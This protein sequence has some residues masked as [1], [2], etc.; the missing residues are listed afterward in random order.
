[1][2]PVP[3]SLD[4]HALEVE[5]RGLACGSP[6]G[7]LCQHVGHA[8]GIVPP[9]CPFGIRDL[10]GGECVMAGFCDGI[11]KG[12]EGCVDQV[13]PIIM[14]PGRD[15]RWCA[16]FGSVWQAWGQ[17]HSELLH[18]HIFVFIFGMVASRGGWWNKCRAVK[19]IDMD[20]HSRV[21][22]S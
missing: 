20:G 12:L 3:L 2:G 1:V 14:I 7:G 11:I 4:Y 16:M 22:R 8:T 5:G 21:V 15:W 6:N 10:S 9:S 18:P 17:Q 19:R 13:P